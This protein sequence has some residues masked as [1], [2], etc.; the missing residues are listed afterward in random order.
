VP[1]EEEEE[2]EEEEE[3]E[4][5]EEECI[6]SKLV[7]QFVTPVWYTDLLFRVF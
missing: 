2:E 3:D 7:L 5:E 4:D 6:T 1:I